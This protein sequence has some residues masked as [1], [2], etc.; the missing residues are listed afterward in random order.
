MNPLSEL[1]AKAQEA[2]EQGIKVISVDY[3]L[4]QFDKE[5]DYYSLA[6]RRPHKAR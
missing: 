4:S 6:S 1:Q 3:I 2:K 5:K